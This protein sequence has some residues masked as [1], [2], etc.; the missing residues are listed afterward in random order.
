MANHADTRTTKLY[1]C[2]ERVITQSAVERIR[3]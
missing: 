2:T 3:V 1:D